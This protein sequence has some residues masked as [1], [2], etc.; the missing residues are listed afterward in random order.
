MAPKPPQT[1][2]LLLIDM[3]HTSVGV[4]PRMLAAWRE[5]LADDTSNERS[6]ESAV[7]L[8]RKLV[9][10]ANAAG[11]PA[12]DAVH[13][14]V[15]TPWVLSSVRTAQYTSEKP[16]L[17]TNR[18]LQ[19]I[20]DKDL[21]RFFSITPEAAGFADHRHILEHQ[22][23]S[24][25]VNGHQLMQPIGQRA[26]E[27]ACT[28]LITG[29]DPD[30]YDQL[31][32][33][34]LVVTHREASIVSVQTTQWKSIRTHMQGAQ[35]YVLFDFHGGFG[36]CMV[37]KDGVM[38]ITAVTPLAE[39]QYQSDLQRALEVAPH[40]IRTMMAMRDAGTLRDDVLE[41]ISDAEVS[42]RSQYQQQ[43]HVLLES[44]VSYGLLP[45]Q[46]FFLT[47]LGESFFGSLLAAPQFADMTVL[48]SPFVP[49]PITTS[50]FADVI[51]THAITKKDVALVLLA[52][53]C[54]SAYNN[55]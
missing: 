45:N 20:D 7:R 46:A 13:C 11:Y 2:T 42:L 9:A 48:R 4:L 12:W 22:R 51:D 52:L 40:E 53:S 8:M 1:K 41:R 5:T 27:V 44:V 36:E 23:L 28:Y 43:L 35:Q 30:Q 6:F 38:T 34:L 16:V 14:S 26:K 19:D 17:V 37:V 50:L 24:V 55:Q 29:M 33:A 49:T 31:Q 18:L 32:S 54:L 3:A 47:G 39:E 25:A 15:G 21:E 10:K